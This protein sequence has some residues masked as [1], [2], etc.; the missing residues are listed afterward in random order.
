MKN[1]YLAPVVGLLLTSHTHAAMAW[2]TIA[3]TFYDAAKSG[4]SQKVQSLLNRGYSINQTDSSGSTALCKAAADNNVR[5][6]NLL[7]QY[8]ANPYVACMNAPKKGFSISPK[9]ILSFESIN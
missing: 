6:Y 2:G 8:G 7:I 4:Q 3:D 5:A 1:L 9:Y